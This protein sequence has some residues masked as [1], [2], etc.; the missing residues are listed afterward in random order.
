[1]HPVLNRNLFLVKEKVALFKA[2]NS[3]DIFDPETGDEI[4]HCRED[5]MGLLTRIL[6]FSDQKTITPFQIDLHTPS[7][8]PI[9]SVKRGIAIFLS[10]VDVLDETQVRIGGFHQKLFSLGPHHAC[11]P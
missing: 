2:A 9:L 10:K 5:R 11:F 7:G 1:M 4:I 3:Y 8:E 6:R